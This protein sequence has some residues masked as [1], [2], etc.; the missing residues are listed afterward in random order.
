MKLVLALASLTSAG[1]LQAASTAAPEAPRDLERRVCTPSTLAGATSIR[2][3]EGGVVIAEADGDAL[4]VRR[5]TG[6]GCALS[7]AGAPA[8]AAAALLDADDLGNVYVFPAE[9]KRASDVSTMLPDEYPGSMV[10]RVDARSVVSKLLPAGRGIWSFGATPRGDGLWVSAC[11]PNG[12]YDITPEGARRASWAMPDTLWEQSASVLSDR[13]TFWSV[14]VRTCAPGAPL[15]PACGFMLT[16]SSPT[17]S[18]EIESTMVD[19]GEGFAQTSLARCGARVCGVAPTGIIVWDALG[20]RV[21]TVT[22]ADLGAAGAE[23]VQQVTGNE[24]GLY[25]IL[26]TATATRVVF[27]PED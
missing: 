22:L 9:A 4:R 26:S 21:A 13:E 25:V 12:V 5:L 8:I 19:L 24:G 20:A 14:G 17:S 27:L 23:R 10:A 15:T 7:D 16:R 11:G 1:C 3:V 2:A 6:D 18:R